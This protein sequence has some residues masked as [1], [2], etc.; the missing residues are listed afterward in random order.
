[1]KSNDFEARILEDYEHSLW[2]ELVV[3]SP[4]GSIFH[5]SDYLQM[6]ADASS[7]KLNIY[8]CFKDDELV[9]GCPLFV[10]ILRGG[11]SFAVS[12]GPL[13]PYG[14]FLLPNQ[15]STNVRKSEL[16]QYGILNAL[17]DRIL[18]DRYS[19]ITITNSPDLLDIRPCL[20]HGWEGRVAYTYYINL[21]NFNRE[22]F[23]R[24]VK[25]NIKK[26]IKSGFYIENL[27]DAELHYKL[28]ERVFQR[29][30]QSVPFERDFL[31]KLIRFIEERNCGNMWVAKDKSGEAVASHIR[32]WDNKRAYAL[33]AASEPSFR[34]SGANQFLFASVLEEI[35]KMG[36]HQINIMHGNAQQ[37]SYYAAGYNPVLVPYYS[38]ARRTLIPSIV[39]AVHTAMK[40]RR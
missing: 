22:N 33:T 8:G 26:A 36:L 25:K 21:D 6:V 18:R 28:I 16:V 39:T 1:M 11:V 38:V 24:D 3:Q 4:Q 15:D 14:G 5:N 13:T 29:Q 37:L 9:G 7:R 10:K 20:W 23:S 31:G 30:N 40:N 27:R 17:C 35:Q 19:S 2:D 34:D 32:V 12:R